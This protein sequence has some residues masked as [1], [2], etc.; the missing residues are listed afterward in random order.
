[1]GLGQIME[2]SKIIL[3][4]LEKCRE[5]IESTKKDIVEIKV[6]QAKNS[7]ILEEHMRRTE[8]NEQQIK[9]QRQFK[10]YFAGIAVIMTTI[11]NIL[12][13]IF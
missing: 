7:T 2:D 3:R 8:A 13:R 5:G 10:W 4:E 9:E 12:G 11:S 1:M 6:Q